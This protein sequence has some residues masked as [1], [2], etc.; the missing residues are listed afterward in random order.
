LFISKY[1]NVI[2]RQGGYWLE[3]I[4]FFLKSSEPS[5]VIDVAFKKLFLDYPGGH[6]GIIATAGG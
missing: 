4:L 2:G 6:F 5:G 3:S 1:E